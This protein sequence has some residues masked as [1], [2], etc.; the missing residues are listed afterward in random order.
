MGDG[1]LSG[2]CE[3]KEGPGGTE[4]HKSPRGTAV[5]LK[6]RRT[7]AAHDLDT[8]PEHALRVPGTERLHGRLFRGKACRERRGEVA[9]AATVGDF[10]LREHPPNEA[11]TVAADSFPET[12]DLRGIE[13][14]SYN[15]HRAR[16]IV[17]EPAPRL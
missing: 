4:R 8:S 15:G 9:L 16:S 7:M 17:Y 12:I 13:S 5:E 6:P 3:R 10:T 11:L 14:G 2:V 1:Q